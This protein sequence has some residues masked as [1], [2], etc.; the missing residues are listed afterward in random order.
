M[1]WHH[2]WYLLCYKNKLKPPFLF[3]VV[4]KFRSILNDSCNVTKMTLSLFTFF[5]CWKITWFAFEIHRL[6]P[7]S[8]HTFSRI[9]LVLKLNDAH[10]VKKA[11]LEFETKQ[12]WKKCALISESNYF[13]WI[14]DSNKVCLEF[15]LGMVEFWTPGRAIFLTQITLL[16]S[17]L[18]AHFFWR[19][20]PRYL[21]IFKVFYFVSL[22]ELS[23]S[24]RII[25][26]PRLTPWSFNQIF[27]IMFWLLMLL[28]YGIHQLLFW[29][30][31]NLSYLSNLAWSLVSKQF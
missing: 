6:V 25:L 22:M 9:S 20:A 15:E 26:I 10:Q 11:R 31:K 24:M 4:A 13:M 19:Y 12:I 14:I 21:P 1:L 16:R 28:F 8:R 30:F 5:C 23:P 17:E 3:S 2:K 18:Q 27:F 7:N 29:L